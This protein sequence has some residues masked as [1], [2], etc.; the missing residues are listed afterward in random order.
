M[1]NVSIG[2]IGLGKMGSNLGL[3][4]KDKGWAVTGYNRSPQK[5]KF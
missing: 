2:L 1:K 5:V 4:L 3:N